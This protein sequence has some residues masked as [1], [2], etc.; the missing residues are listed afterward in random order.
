MDGRSARHYPGLDGLR[1]LAI[2]LVVPHN[3]DIVAPVLHGPF[4]YLT[5][6]IDR[7]WVGVQLFFVLSGFLITEQLCRSRDAANYYGGFYARRALRIFPL[8]LAAVLLALLLE[9]VLP[10]RADLG[11]GSPVWY[12]WLAIFFINWTRPLGGLGIPGFPQFW[13][14]ALEEQFYLVWP[15][16]VRMLASRLAL[17]SGA[18][19]MAALAARF[20]MLRL[21]AS[22]DMVYMWTI[23]R[24]DALAFGALAALVVQRWRA[25][26]EIPAPTTFIVGSAAVAIVGALATRLYEDA[27]W[28]TQTVGFTFLGAACWLI[29]LGTV[30]NDLSAKQ[31]WWLAPL[32]SRA[33]ISVGRYSYGMYV[34]HMFFAIFAAVWVRRVTA[35]FGQGSM[36]AFALLITALSYAVGFLSYHLYEKHFLRLSH[37]YFAPR[38]VAAK[39]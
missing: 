18:I 20:V 31:R 21:G 24:M 30:A 3:A 16:V 6:L 22:S 28:P 15:L 13:S 38:E 10:A 8:F 1:G 36:L 34:F 33:L 2:L 11:S 35:S 25:S 39:P 37:R 19:I 9:K 23:A 26:G 17:V 7:G 12:F 32:R 27:T 5:I 4:R 29:L 14:L